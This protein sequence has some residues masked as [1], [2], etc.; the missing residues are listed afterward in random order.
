MIEADA[1]LIKG[2]IITF[3]GIALRAIKRRKTD[4]DFNG[5]EWNAG[6]VSIIPQR[7][8]SVS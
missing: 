3:K 8:W 6:D 2:K 1:S 4:T 7:L 5:I